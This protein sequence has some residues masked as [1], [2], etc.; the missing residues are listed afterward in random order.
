[1]VPDAY[2]EAIGQE[3]LDVVDLPA[4]SDVKLDR[5]KLSFK[6]TVEVNPEIKLKNYKGLIVNY[7]KV[8]VSPEELK[9]ELDA[10]KE[11]RKIDAL[12]DS[13][14]KGMGFPDIQELE[15]A[16]S[17]QII[18]HK[19]DR[20]RQKIENE[21]IEQI[22]GDL[23]FQ[24]PASLV[25]RQLEDLVRHA[26]LDLAM[27]GLSR[28]KIEDEEQELKKNLQEEARRQVKVYLVLS[29]IAKKEGVEIGDHMPR[30]VME[31][32]LREAEWKVT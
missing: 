1:M 9:K 5:T 24:L 27:K 8:T 32:L 16:I 21:I 28:Q 7:R 3:K 29:E 4:I 25:S 23:D 10:L 2:N 22:S 20:E 14:A 6:A 18:S 17:R 19:E 12:N 15:K 31:L 26:K 13:L 30:Q 11:A